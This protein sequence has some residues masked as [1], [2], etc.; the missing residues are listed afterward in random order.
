MP[1]TTCNNIN[2]ILGYT[3]TQHVTEC[4][5]YAIANQEHEP[6]GFYVTHLL[7]W[8][9]CGHVDGC[10]GAKTFDSAG[11]YEKLVGG[12]RVEMHKYMVCTIP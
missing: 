1:L 10:G 11:S 3:V 2:D 9:I 6:F 4:L 8:D 12:S 5:K 7:T